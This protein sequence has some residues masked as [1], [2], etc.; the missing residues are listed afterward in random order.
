M[1]NEARDGGGPTP[2]GKVV[3]TDNHVWCRFAGEGRGDCAHFIGLPGKSIPCQ[4]DGPD[5][6]VDVYGIPNG[7]CEYCWCSHQLS[8][9]RTKNRELNELL[10]EHRQQ[11]ANKCLEL[12]EARKLI[13]PGGSDLL[14][15]AVERWN[16]EVKNRPLV[17]VNRR[18]LDETW[19]Q[20][21]RYAG[22]DDRELIGPAHDELVAKR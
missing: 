14:S 3:S 9:A 16:R 13:P 17:N 1:S 2:V 19:R 11:Y 4:H 21:I 15:W 8:E 7:W 22:G 10:E 18:T 5:D 12:I 20:V 6:T